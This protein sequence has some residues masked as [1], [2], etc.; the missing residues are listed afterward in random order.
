MA[1][2]QKIMNTPQM[3]LHNQVDVWH[4]NR[5]LGKM[6][7]VTANMRVISVN[8]N[9]IRPKR[10]RKDGLRHASLHHYSVTTF[11]RRAVY[12]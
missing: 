12:F 1:G 6:I 10:P 2:I 5:G 8:R 9:T 7:Q 4:G 11:D 3:E